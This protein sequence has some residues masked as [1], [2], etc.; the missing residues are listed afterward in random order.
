MFEAPR[1]QQATLE[2]DPHAEANFLGPKKQLLDW[3]N[4]ELDRLH[5][6]G[7]VYPAAQ[8]PPPDETIAI[9][10]KRA[11]RKRCHTQP[12]SAH[13]RVPALQPGGWDARQI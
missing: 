13:V 7:Y 6:D 1:I 3:Y 12:V 11:V 4:S 2:T 5:L 10:P 8:M 9:R